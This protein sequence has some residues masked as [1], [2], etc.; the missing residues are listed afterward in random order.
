MRPARRMAARAAL[1]VLGLCA[2]LYC[3]PAAAQEVQTISATGEQ[4]ILRKPVFEAAGAGHPDVV[5]VEYFDYNCGYCKKYAPTLRAL[6]A[7][8]GRLSVVYKDWPILGVVSMYAAQSALAAQWQGKYLAAHD[9]LMGASHLSQTDQV[10]GILRTAGV[11]L[12]AL[13]RDRALH[14]REIEDLLA[15]DDSEAQALGL[16]GT[17]G[18][19][20]GRQL[21]DGMTDMDGMRQLVAAAR[22]R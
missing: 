14:A 2:P 8:D 16:Q 5:I 17:P 1:C 15:R 22:K 11:D 6:L 7:K 19:L 18:I 4:A 10:D 20:V 3:V 13:R 21:I 12:E 9:A